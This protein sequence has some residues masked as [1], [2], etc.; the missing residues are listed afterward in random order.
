MEMQSF[1]SIFCS[2]LSLSWILHTYIL[3]VPVYH[4]PPNVFIFN[5]LLVYQALCLEHLSAHE[6]LVKVTSKLGLQPAEVSSFVRVTL[7]GIMVLVDDTVSEEVTGVGD[8]SHSPVPFSLLSNPLLSSL[9][10]LSPSFPP[11]SLTSFLPS[12]LPFPPPP[13]PPSS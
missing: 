1:I 12:L 8:R 10:F 9:F 5:I 6:L 2:L 7:T 13:S 11:P 3:Y 4:V